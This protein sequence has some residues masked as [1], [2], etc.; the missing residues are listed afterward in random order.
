M[1]RFP[2]CNTL[3]GFLIVEELRRCGC[4]RFVVC[5]GSRSTPLVMGVD[6]ARA[7]SITHFDERGAAF[8][9][10]GHARAT[11]KPAALI[12]TSGTAVANPF[13]AVVEASMDQVPL[14]LLTADRPPELRDTGANQTIHQPGI[15]GQYTR[16]EYELPCPDP[17]LDPR[18]VLTASDQLYFCALATPSGPVH[19]N[20]PF[21][22]PL[23]PT[24]DGVD[25]SQATSLLSNWLESDKPFTA[26]PLPCVRPSDETVESLATQIRSTKRGLLIAGRF[27][28]RTDREAVTALANHLGWPVYRDTLSGVPRSET[29]LDRLDPLLAANPKV[30]EPPETI[31]QFGGPLVSKAVA[32]WSAHAGRVILVHRSPERIDPWHV[33]TCRVVADI[34][35]TCDALTRLAKRMSPSSWCDQL[36]RL[37]DEA[38]SLLQQELAAAGGVTEAAIVQH[39]L[40][41]IP[42]DWGVMVGS[43]L[44]I[45]DC[46]Q[47]RPRITEN[48]NIVSNRGASGIDGTLATACGYAAGRGKP[49]LCLLGDQAL[50]HDLNSLALAAGSS[51]PMKIALINN[52]GGRIFEQLPIG[53]FAQL[54]AKYF[55]AEHKYEF[56]GA[57]QMFGL[58]YSSC[59]SIGDLDAACTQIFTDP[60]SSLTEFRVDPKQDRAFRNRLLDR[61]RS[62]R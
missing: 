23:A 59:E 54:V 61:L 5:P 42:G 49:T 62:L 18:L 7:S 17:S 41:N 55:A 48:R 33:V 60:T 30:I 44:P 24:S 1:S 13:P 45:R 3:W 58:P 10:L 22:E 2:N 27:S 51:V 36:L 29:V 11:G 47:Y 19:L 32:Q 37:N 15:F 4:S 20:I 52:G 39:L 9:A 50:L 46:E 25:L 28:N 12:C 31:V 34:A 21:R 53:Q 38:E 56:R 14:I 16:W 40:Q 8:F 6:L 43:S 26:T 35:S 57:A